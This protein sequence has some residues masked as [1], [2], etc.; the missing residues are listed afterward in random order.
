MS[1]DE[2]RDTADTETDIDTGRTREEKLRALVRKDIHPEI[3]AMA[4][5]ALRRR[6]EGSS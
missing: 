2:T 5:K 6:Q 1:T 3:T 4:E